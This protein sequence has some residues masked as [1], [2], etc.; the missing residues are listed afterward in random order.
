MPY[1]EGG[2][3]EQ[4]CNPVAIVPQTRRTRQGRAASVARQVRGKNFEAIRKGS[5]LCIPGF[6]P[7]A[8]A[9]DHQEARS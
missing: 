3:V 8:N 7:K 1:H 6:R 5:D 9:M 4:S 2:L